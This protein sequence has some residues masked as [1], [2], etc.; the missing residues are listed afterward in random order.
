MVD[1]KDPL[2]ISRVAASDELLIRLLLAQT[3]TLRDRT[4]DYDT[5]EGSGI[6]LATA[7]RLAASIAQSTGLSEEAFL[8]LAKSGL[9]QHRPISA[10][11]DPGVARWMNTYKEFYSNRV[12]P[13]TF[14]APPTLH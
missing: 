11:Q 14:D 2:V 1:P 3:G 9:R 8:N 10:L 12:P 5:P 6:A 4:L 13:G 7:F